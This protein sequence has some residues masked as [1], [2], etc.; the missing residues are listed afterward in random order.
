D[1][2]P[3]KGNIQCFMSG[4]GID[5]EP[6][7]QQGIMLFSGLGFGIE[8][9]KGLCHGRILSR[10]EGPRTT[11]HPGALPITPTGPL[12]GESREAVMEREGGMPVRVPE[13]APSA[14]PTAKGSAEPMGYGHRL[15]LMACR[16]G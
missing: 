4:Q 6:L 12:A 3:L 5:A 1:H 8:N 14:H 13:P 9:V 10:K 15:H 7:E 2:Q 16:Q 11:A